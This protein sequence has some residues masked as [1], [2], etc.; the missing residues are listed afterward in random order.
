MGMKLGNKKTTEL[1][2]IIHE[3]IMQARIKIW[4]MRHNKYIS[5]AEIDDILYDLTISAPK[6]VIESFEI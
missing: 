3:E 5:I 2:G 4:G 6:K 1:Y